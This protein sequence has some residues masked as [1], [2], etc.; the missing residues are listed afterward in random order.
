MPEAK[1]FRLFANESAAGF[2]RLSRNAP[3]K[4]ET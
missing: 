4:Q 2:P 1:L 3:D